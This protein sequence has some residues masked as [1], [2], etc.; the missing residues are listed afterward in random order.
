M[1]RFV[2]V[3]IL[4]WMNMGYVPGLS[5]FGCSGGGGGGGVTPQ[6]V[7]IDG[8][9]FE[10]EPGEIVIDGV[11]FPYAPT[12]ITIEGVEVFIPPNRG[13][14][15]GDGWTNAGARAWTPWKTPA[16]PYCAPHNVR[17]APPNVMRSV[18]FGV[19]DGCV[20]IPAETREDPLYVLIC[21][22][23]QICVGD[24]C[25][26]VEWTCDEIH[27]IDMSNCDW[28]PSPDGRWVCWVGKSEVLQ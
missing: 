27:D 17:V 20:P 2:I 12:T 7:V 18:R 4:G 10:L 19:I 16:D 23:S 25:G 6:T 21:D 9:A 14:G 8:E 15:S 3:A 28:Q 26:P 1:K 13:S 11:V 22:E 24:F 5:G